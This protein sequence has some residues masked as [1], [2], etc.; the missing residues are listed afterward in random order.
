MNKSPN[1][2][3]TGAAAIVMSSIVLS[4]LT[5]FVREILVPNLIGVNMVSDAYILA[6][7]ITGLIYDLLVGGAISAA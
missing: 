5:G 2:K 7:K 6:F 4:R 3:L 1:K